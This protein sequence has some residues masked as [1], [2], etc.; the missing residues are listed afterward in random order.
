MKIYIYAAILIAVL[1]G[2]WWLSGTRV[3]ALEAKLNE[4]AAEHQV[5]VERL[6]GELKL[7]TL[8][9]KALQDERDKKIKELDG[10]KKYSLDE[11][12]PFIGELLGPP[13]CQAR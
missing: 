3:R 7:Q 5:N 11:C 6:K 10:T 2:I 13:T 12:V 4:A 8:K 9:A 1:L